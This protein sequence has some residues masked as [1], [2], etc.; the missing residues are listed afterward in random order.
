MIAGHLDGSPAETFGLADRLPRNAAEQ[1]HETLTEL[2]RVCHRR[3]PGAIRPDLDLHRRFF[4]PVAQGNRLRK[5]LLSIDPYTPPGPIQPSLALAVD[6]ER[7]LITPE[8]RVAIELLD[9]A[10]EGAG[11]QVTVDVQLAAVREHDLLA[12][13]RDWGRH[14]LRSVIDLL[15]GGEKPLQIPAIGA[16]LTLLV[17]RSD[18]PERAIARF[19]PGTARDVI[20]DVFRTCANAFSE[21]L[22]PSTRRATNKERLISGWTLGE[23]ARRMPDALQSSDA[24]GVYVVGDRRP[25][26]I[27]L[28]VSELARREGVD[29]RRLEEAFDSLVR[30][31]AK[32]SQALAGYELLFARPAETERLRASLLDAWE[33]NLQA[34]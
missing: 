19:S 24:H 8:G 22:A 20:D 30:E 14:R 11:E 32:R 7:L 27:G 10:I 13:Y 6:A 2:W 29:K 3:A 18:S 12:L 25:E 5:A 17:N 34:P 15:G 4:D 1:L 33:Q 26:L 28:I 23:I 16:V 21:Q 9:R 31:F